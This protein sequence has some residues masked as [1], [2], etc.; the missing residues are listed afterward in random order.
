M[1]RARRTRR[2]RERA[3]EIRRD[4]S[5]SA[6]FQSIRRRA[7]AEDT[8]LRSCEVRHLATFNLR[9]PAILVGAGTRKVGVARSSYSSK[10][11]S[12]SRSESRTT[13]HTLLYPRS[14]FA[15]E[16]AAP[17]E[18]HDGIPVSGR[19]RRQPP[20]TDR[21]KARCRVARVRR[22]QLRRPRR[23]SSPESPIGTVG[24]GCDCSGTPVEA[25]HAFGSLEATRAGDGF[26]DTLRSE[27]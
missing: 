13:S 14:L 27:A 10:S 1:P 9:N 26:G 6:L 15:E 18:R 2:E 12:M 25:C 19:P 22:G 11:R 24:R 4:S 23:R 8:R 5:V 20:F 16:H 3:S 7:A 21:R 17:L